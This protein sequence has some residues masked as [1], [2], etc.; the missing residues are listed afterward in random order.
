[1]AKIDFDKLTRITGLIYETSAR[2]A[3]LD[4]APVRDQRGAR[5]GKGTP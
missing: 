1:V 4:H 2:L 3:D 5:A